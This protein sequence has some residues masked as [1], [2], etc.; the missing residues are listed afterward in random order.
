MNKLKKLAA[1]LSFFIKNPK[2]I[3]YFFL[4]L[5]HSILNLKLNDSPW[6]PFEA[7]DYLNENL[8]KEMIVFE[9]GSGGSTNFFAKRVK[10]VISVEHNSDWHDIVTDNLAKTELSNYSYLLIE[11][12]KDGDLKEI[13]AQFKSTDNNYLNFN[14]KNYCD[15]INSYPDKYFDLIFIDGRARNACLKN[16]LPK[17]KD[18]GMIV[19]DN[20]DR[21]EYDSGKLLLKNF[22]QKKIY[23]PGPICPA[24]WETTFFTK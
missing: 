24:F 16:S 22:K 12:E 14:F 6:T 3:K 20:S 5:N 13:E 7:R 9:W 19:L 4:W 15:A 11:P 21:K 8:N 2:K 10:K 17:I 1:H 23:G 18:A